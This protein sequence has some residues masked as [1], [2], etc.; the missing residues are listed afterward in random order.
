[1]Y[2]II[3]FK[4]VFYIYWSLEVSWDIFQKYNALFVKNVV[5]FQLQIITRHLKIHFSERQFPFQLIS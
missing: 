4:G 5:T 2:A 1:M 3:Y